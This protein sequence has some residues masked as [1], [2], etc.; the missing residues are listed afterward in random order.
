MSVVIP[1]IS[2]FDCISNVVFSLIPTWRELGKLPI[3]TAIYNILH[4]HEFIVRVIFTYVHFSS[5]FIF[6]LFIYSY[7]QEPLT[8]N[9]YFAI[10]MNIRVDKLNRVHSCAIVKW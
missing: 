1:I 8:K 7:I 9:I 3:F 10:L 4:L 5:L 6:I 2:I